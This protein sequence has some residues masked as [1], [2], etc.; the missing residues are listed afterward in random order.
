[1]VHKFSKIAIKR[2]KPNR[3]IEIRNS[4]LSLKRVRALALNYS[5][6]K[7]PHFVPNSA[8][9]KQFIYT[10]AFRP[11]FSSFFRGFEFCFHVPNM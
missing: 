3:T 11:I 4:W 6:C 10:D 7:F 9:L 8:Y 1:M 2:Y 5:Y